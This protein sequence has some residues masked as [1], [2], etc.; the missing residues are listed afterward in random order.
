MRW[1][2]LQTSEVEGVPGAAGLSS[3]GSGSERYFA[4]CRF[5][6]TFQSMRLGHQKRYEMFATVVFSRAGSSLG[7]RDG[8]VTPFR[9]Q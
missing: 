5:L 9:S 6:A 8:R 2:A 1:R 3:T 7:E 4:V